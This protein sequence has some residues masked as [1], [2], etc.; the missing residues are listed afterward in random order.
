MNIHTLRLHCQ[1][2]CV[3]NQ[4][5]MFAREDHA[6]RDDFGNLVAGGNGRLLHRREAGFSKSFFAAARQPVEP[7]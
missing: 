2:K 5:E 6:W 3:W 1:L 7:L 4:F